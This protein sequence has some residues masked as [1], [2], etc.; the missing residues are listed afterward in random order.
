MRVC[1]F[2]D[3][4]DAYK[5]KGWAHSLSEA[6][7]LNPR[8]LCVWQGLTCRKPS[9]I[10]FQRAL[11][12]EAEKGSRGVLGS[13]PVT[14]WPSQLA[15]FPT[16]SQRVCL[17]FSHLCLAKSWRMLSE[18][19]LHIPSLPPSPA[20][21]RNLNCVA[22]ALHW[23]VSRRKLAPAADGQVTEP[24]VWGSSHSQTDCSTCTTELP[25]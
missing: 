5:T 9:L 3:L 4:P 1:L 13:S 6:P 12:Q 15:P 10:A 17:F 21:Q 16:S 20:F 14:V 7:E 2:V 18:C 25:G 22:M 11:E 19:T 23:L 8:A 24:C